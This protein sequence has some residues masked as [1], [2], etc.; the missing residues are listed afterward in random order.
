MYVE[1]RSNFHAN[2]IIKLLNGG[3]RYINLMCSFTEGKRCIRLELF[4]Q[5]DYD[6]VTQANIFE[7]TAEI[8]L[9]LS[10]LI[11]AVQLK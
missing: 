8:V 4:I 10:M 11:S 5:M 6:N 7:M 1:E 9:S 2:S 3:N